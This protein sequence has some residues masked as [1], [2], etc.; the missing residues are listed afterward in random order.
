M[1]WFF[2][3]YAGHVTD[4]RRRGCRRARAPTWPGC[5]PAV[6]VTAEFDPLRDEGEAYAAALSAAAELPVGGAHA[7]RVKRTRIE[8]AA[9]GR[10]AEV[11]MA[12][13]AA[14]A[15]GVVGVEVAV[16]HVVPVGIVPRPRDRWPAGPRCCPPSATSGW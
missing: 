16:G 5:R 7:L 2:D 8:V 12:D 14:L 15:V 9:P 1:E 11:A 6:V 4:A 3:H 10:G 13:R